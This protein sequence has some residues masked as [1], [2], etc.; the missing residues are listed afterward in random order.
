MRRP[1]SRIPSSAPASLEEA[2]VEAVVKEC[3]H[4]LAP[5][6]L[7]DPLFEIECQDRGGYFASFVFVSEA[8]FFEE[9]TSRRLEIAELASELG[10]NLLLYPRTWTR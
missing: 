4:Q 3:I 1:I 2:H 10:V 8:Q 5:G 7:S 9:L 6:V